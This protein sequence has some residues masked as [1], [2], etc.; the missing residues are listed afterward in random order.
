MQVETLF[1]LHFTLAGE[2]ESLMGVP[3]F[4]PM[5]GRRASSM[6]CHA[7]RKYANELW[8][9]MAAGCDFPSIRKPFSKK[10]FA[11]IQT[12]RPGRVRL[13]WVKQYGST[14][15]AMMMPFCFAFALLTDNIGTGDRK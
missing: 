15:A 6:L 2:C 14:L 12:A 7:S 9:G 10:T 3:F 13:S 8:C 5:G 1:A 11:V 4:L